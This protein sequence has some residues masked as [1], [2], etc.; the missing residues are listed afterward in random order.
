MSHHSSAKPL[1]REV[2]DYLP[3]HVNAWV[4]EDEIL[5]GESVGER[6][7]TAINADTD[8]LIV[9]FDSR[10]AQSVWVGTELE[11]AL[12]EERRIKRPFILPVVLEDGLEDHFPWSRDR[13]YLR[14]SGFNESQVRYLAHEISSSLFAWLSRDLEML[15]AQPTDSSSRLLF[16]DRADALL[17][18]A[19]RHVRNIVFPHRRDRPL[20]LTELLVQ[21]S[22]ETDLGLNDLDDLHA[23]LYRL[24]DRKMISGIAM[25][26]RTIFVGEEHLNW[27]SQE[28]VEE[29]RL[30]AEHVADSIQD[31]WTVYLDGG[32]STFALCKAICRGVRFQQWHHLT[33]VTNAAP[34][35]AEFSD[36]A[37]ELG[38]E[39]EDSRLRVIVNGGEM[40]LNTSVLI[41][42]DGAVFPRIG[43]EHYD[44]TVVGTN[45]VSIEF[46]C[47]TTAPSE[48][49]GKR[50]ALERGDRRFVLAEPSKY[51]VWQ[52]EQFAGFDDGLTILTACAEPDERVEQIV[53]E[54]AGT[55]SEVVIVPMSS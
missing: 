48:A 52:T 8:F 55:P 34:I 1:V 38:M 40:R 7:R 46:G 3:E 54:V 47:T 33:V 19:A 22:E 25:T 51:G 36:L 27:R 14:C 23:L 49:H 53:R 20:P 44:L 43:I 18:D 29:K 35:A 31:G 30:V 41:D 37:N 42:A 50:R 16:A 13:L 10:A 45:G 12:A 39:D 21:L 17:A 5:V 6:L 24:R 2:R 32:S 11:W 4:D 15:R 28:A 9:F 26:G